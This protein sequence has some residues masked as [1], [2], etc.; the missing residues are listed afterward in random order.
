MRPLRLS[1]CNKKKYLYILFLYTSI[2]DIDPN[3]AKQNT[4]CP[5]TITIIII[6]FLI[7]VKLY[8]AISH[9]DE[10]NEELQLFR[11][12]FFIW[13]YWIK[14]LNEHILLPGVLNLRDFYSV[15]VDLFKTR[16]IKGW[17]LL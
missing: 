16:Y 14:L 1:P 2:K 7:F 4:A 10:F 15:L 17:D 9:S 8:T 12:L 13:I 6:K 3:S 5:W 11:S